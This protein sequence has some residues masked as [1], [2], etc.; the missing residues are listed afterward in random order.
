M[1]KEGKS[2]NQIVKLKTDIV[3][4]KI[5]GDPKNKNIIVAFLSDILEIPK[6]SI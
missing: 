6:E 5:F 3:F 2:R 1:Y 4:K